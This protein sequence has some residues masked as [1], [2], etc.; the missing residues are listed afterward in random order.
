MAK[1]KL[2]QFID[3]IEKRPYEGTLD[4]NYVENVR[5]YMDKED[6]DE[7]WRRIEKVFKKITAK[8]IAMEPPQSEE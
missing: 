7:E 8:I 5:A 4:S 1:H 2:Q 3:A 6:K